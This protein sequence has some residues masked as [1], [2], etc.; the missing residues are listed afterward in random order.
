MFIA[1]IN[2]N[3]RR[4]RENVRH[5]HENIISFMIKKFQ[6]WTGMKKVTEEERNIQM[7]SEYYDPIERFPEKID[8]L[9]NAL[10]QIEI[11]EYNCQKDEQLANA[12]HEK[13]LETNVYLQHLINE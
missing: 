6:Y 10:N 12:T 5:N 1:I 4:A 9:L 7:R 2:D 8:Q 3:F 11:K 13:D